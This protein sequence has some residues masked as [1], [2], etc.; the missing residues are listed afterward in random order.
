[1]YEEVMPPLVYDLASIEEDERF[2][3]PMCKAFQGRKQVKR[4]RKGDKP[5]KQTLSQ[6]C[7][8]CG[9][10]DHNIR[11][12]PDPVQQRKRQRV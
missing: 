6:V 12:C 8:W 10:A 3:A 1:M 9:K 5:Q 2:A 11:R 4:K 7:G